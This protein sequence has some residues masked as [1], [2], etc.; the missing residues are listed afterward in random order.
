MGTIEL[1][2]RLVQT[3]LETEKNVTESFG[4]L[5]EELRNVQLAMLENTFEQQK[6]AAADCIDAIDRQ[7]IELS[8]CI[9]EYRQ[10]Q[11]SLA[12]SSEAISHLRGGAPVMPPQIDGETMVSFVSQRIDDLKSQGKI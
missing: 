10:L 2:D 4:R 7:L 5:N 11:L 9:E 8:A 6:N 3:F 12:N 1:F